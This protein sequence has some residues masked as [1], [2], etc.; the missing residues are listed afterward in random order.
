MGILEIIA[1]QRLG[2]KEWEAHPDL[3]AA[4]GRIEQSVCRPNLL[5]DEKARITSVVELCFAYEREDDLDEKL[6]IL[7]T[8]EEVSA[9]EPIELPKESIEEWDRKLESTDKAYAKAKQKLEQRRETFKQRY[10]SLRAKAGLQTQEAVAKKAGLRRSYVGVIET[11]E[12]LPQQKTLQKLA[13]A[14]GVD[15]TELLA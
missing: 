14:F 10:F 5:E 2:P 1:E 11:G 12:H 3:R 8:L 13:K 6:N 7:R 4:L 15:V 9:N